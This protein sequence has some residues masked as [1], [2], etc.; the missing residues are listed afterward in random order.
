M[1][2]KIH[3]H[4][5]ANILGRRRSDRETTV[6]TVIKETNLSDGYTENNVNAKAVVN[7]I[8]DLHNEV[9]DRMTIARA[10][11][12]TDSEG[13]LVWDALENGPVTYTDL[14]ITSKT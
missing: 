9:V 7:I 14:L 5:S 3:R 13:K 4:F 6:V 8:T 2:L 1:K 12:P 11:I 10:A